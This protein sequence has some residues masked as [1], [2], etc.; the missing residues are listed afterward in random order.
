MASIDMKKKKNQAGDFW[1]FFL[2]GVNR[3]FKSDCKGV[4]DRD[5]LIWVPENKDARGVK[6][7]RLLLTER[8]Y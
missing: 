7:S 5:I 1:N 2:P 8:E 3:V 6:V 4:S